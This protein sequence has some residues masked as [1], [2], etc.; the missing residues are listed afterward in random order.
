MRRRSSRSILSLPV[1]VIGL[2]VAAQVFMPAA[3][4]WHEVAAHAALPDHNGSKSP[5][6][7][8]DADSSCGT[9]QAIALSRLADF[10]LP[11]I[12]VDF[13]TLRPEC[14]LTIPVLTPVEGPRLYAHAPRG[15]PALT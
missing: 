2:L 8:H 10:T 15:P 9:C 14:V 7:H 12:F 5:G 1:I 11:P 13:L 3:R 4:L 6:H